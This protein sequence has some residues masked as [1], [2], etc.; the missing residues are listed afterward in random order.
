[1]SGRV[2]MGE[3]MT[4]IPPRLFESEVL[5]L[6]G[7]TK[8]TLESW[9]WKSRF[10]KPLYRTKYNGAVYS[11]LAVYKALGFIQE[12]KEDPFDVNG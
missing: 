2:Y 9:K 3:R 1:M 5:S 10:P 4:D 11:G 6:S 7:I 12:K 8:S